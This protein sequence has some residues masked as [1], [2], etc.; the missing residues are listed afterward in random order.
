MRPLW[1]ALGCLGLAC[2]APTPAT[3]LP[4]VA[5]T[6]Q[7]ACGQASD[8]TVRIMQG[9]APTCA[10]CHTSGPRG[11]FASVS[12]FQSLVVSN[13]AVITPG[14]PD[15]SEFVRLLEARGTGAFTQ[16]PIGTRT[17]TQLLADGT[18]TVSLAD[19]RQWVTGLTVQA[20]DARPDVTAPRVSRLRP[21]QVQRAL[22]QQLGL[23]YD[24]F[25]INTEDYGITSAETRGD[26]LYPLQLPDGVPAARESQPLDRAQG[27]GAASTMAQRRADLSVSPTFVLT[28]TQVSQRWCRLALAKQGN[29]ALFPAGTARTTDEANVR[30]TL[31]RWFLHFHGRVATDAQVEAM[32]STVWLP[33]S[34]G[35][36]EAG[37]VGV[38]SAFLRHPDWI[39]Y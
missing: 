3:A 9:L 33:L 6:H 19:V 15:A 8:E 29:V 30:L 32:Y 10:G 16:M 39:F 23:G 22:Y 7:A 37:W 36:T 1:L 31:R 13:P 2:S 21:E 18:A 35:S 34:Q 38:C 28:L 17:Y 14:D 26:D 24:D 5:V 12:A 25:F 11:F 4:A 20:R 27:L